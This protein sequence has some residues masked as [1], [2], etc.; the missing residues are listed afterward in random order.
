[1]A[2][3]FLELVAAVTQPPGERQRLALDGQLVVVDHAGVPQFERLC[4]RAYSPGSAASRR[5]RS[6]RE[7]RHSSTADEMI[8]SS[9]NTDLNHA[10]HRGQ[11]AHDLSSV[12]SVLTQRRPR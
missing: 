4:R 1:M 11:N 7:Q 10:A 2:E 12:D 3:A 5:P 6:Q 8:E 9:E